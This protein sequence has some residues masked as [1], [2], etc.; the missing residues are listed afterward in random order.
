MDTKQLLELRKKIKSTKPNF[1]VK[2]SHYVAGV[3]KRWRFPRGRHS[4]VR[5][6]H[7]GRPALV[8]PGYGSPRAVRG[9]HPSGLEE[10]L[11]HNS[12]EL[13]SLNPLHQG[14]V[15]SSGLGDRK[16]LSLL[17]LAHEKKIPVLN[18]KDSAVVAEEIKTSFAARVKLRQDKL[19]QK[20]KKLQEKVKKAEE[21]KEQEN[22]EL[23][24]KKEEA[25]TPEAMEQK[26]EQQEAEKK[27]Q[28][29]MIEKTITK[30]Q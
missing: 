16:K 9:L 18:V 29:K 21:K 6:E 1:V 25:S 26:K 14:A 28:Q 24:K 10:V 23:S 30:R 7:N 8:T 13:L 5:Q 15:L 12:M 4:K 11:V 27:E 22:K 20:T 19:Q 2:E 17:T 3:K